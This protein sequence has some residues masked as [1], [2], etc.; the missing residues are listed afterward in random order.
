VAK[1]KEARPRPWIVLLDGDVHF[2]CRTRAVARDYARWLRRH[3]GT[4]DA[5]LFHDGGH[6]Q[7]EKQEGLMID[8]NGEEKI[9]D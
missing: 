2:R 9:D 7:A 1:S 4:R 6:V 3:P 8:E 5:A